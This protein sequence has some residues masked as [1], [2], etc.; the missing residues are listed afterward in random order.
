M[1]FDKWKENIRRFKNLAIESPVAMFGGHA[2]ALSGSA[3]AIAGFNMI[4]GAAVFAASGLSLAWYA[5]SYS[6]NDILAREYTEIFHSK[7]YGKTVIL[8]ALN[9]L[10]KLGVTEPREVLKRALH[11]FMLV[12]RSQGP[13]GL[14]GHR[15]ESTAA[16][17]TFEKHMPV[18]ATLAHDQLMLEALHVLLTVSGARRD[19]D[20]PLPTTLQQQILTNKPEWIVLNESAFE[21]LVVE[22]Y[23]PG[24]L[25]TIK[26]LRSLNYAE[27]ELREAL[28]DWHSSQT[29]APINET[30]LPT[31]LVL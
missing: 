5:S 12:S 19:A 30:N 3:V 31:T 15:R 11:S 29:A 28:I 1:T 27:Q 2:A 4:Q 20:E 9:T 24:L 8:E 26:S 21:D 25:S 13:Q 23:C 17:I 10:E 14:M 16:G 6:I 18:D 7:S 22:A